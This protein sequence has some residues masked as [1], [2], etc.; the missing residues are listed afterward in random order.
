M[1]AAMIMMEIFKDL[2]FAFRKRS[3][4]DPEVLLSVDLLLP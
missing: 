3:R 2:I 1:K 4:R